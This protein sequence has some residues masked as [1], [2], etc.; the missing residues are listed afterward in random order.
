MNCSK[1]LANSMLLV[2]NSAALLPCQPHFQAP[3]RNKDLL[4]FH[5]YCVIK[6]KLFLLTLICEF[7]HFHC[8][9]S[10]QHLSPVSVAWN[11]LEHFSSPST[12]ILAHCRVAHCTEGE[13]V[14]VIPLT[15]EHN[16]ITVARFKCTMVNLKPS[17]AH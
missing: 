15:Q 17:L 9:P 3:E 12:W 11:D 4:D 16:T 5:T 2:K 6:Q 14:R 8:T 1:F 13:A 10:D 7:G